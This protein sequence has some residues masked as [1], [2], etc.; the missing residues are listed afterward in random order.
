MGPGSVVRRLRQE[1][2]WTLEDL[3][4]A[5]QQSPVLKGK[6]KSWFALFETNGVR[7]QEELR[8]AFASVFGLSLK[9]FDAMWRGLGKPLQTAEN[10]GIPVVNLS[11]AGTPI[12]YH[13][14]GITSRIGHRYL[15]RDG[16]TKSEDL[17]AVQVVGDS[18]SPRIMEGDDVILWPVPDGY[19][20]S[21]LEAKVVF[22]HFRDDDTNCLARVHWLKE[23]DPERGRRLELRK[24]NPK[25][26]SRKVWFA[27]LDQFAVMVQFRGKA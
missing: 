22:V 6:S 17:F 13:D 25:H 26:K 9:E 7:P 16:D 10:A 2:F 14:H 11:P 1:R 5:A 27:D 21:Q 19:P 4:D 18:M 15:P 20:E 12:N 23:Q 24:D 8:G 3:R